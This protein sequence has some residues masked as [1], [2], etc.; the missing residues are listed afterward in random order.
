[1][2]LSRSPDACV[3]CERGRRCALGSCFR[4]WRCCEDHGSQLLE[5]SKYC[6][7][8]SASDSSIICTQNERALCWRSN[9]AY[10]GDRKFGTGTLLCSLKKKATVCFCSVFHHFIQGSVKVLARKIHFFSWQF[11]ETH[12][13]LLH[14]RTLSFPHRQHQS[15]PAWSLIS[16]FL[17]LT[18]LSLPS[19]Q[20]RRL[21]SFPCTRCPLPRHCFWGRLFC[22]SVEFAGV[23]MGVGKET[24]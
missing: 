22:V 21:G 24:H 6:S 16:P 5:K 10:L 9:A 4:S 14:L 20:T 12:V 2:P 7:S 19:F 3:I 13:F 15:F 8:Y 17:P 11:P 23:V 1:M 18:G